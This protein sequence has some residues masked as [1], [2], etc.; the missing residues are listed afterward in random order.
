MADAVEKVLCGGHAKFL[1][2]A[3]ALDAVGR[4]GPC[5][6]LRDRCVIFLVSWQR[7]LLPSLD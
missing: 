3:G 2:A 7:P 5:R 4:E 6:S 1:R